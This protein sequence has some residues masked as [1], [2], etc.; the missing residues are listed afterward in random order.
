MRKKIAVALAVVSGVYLF[1]PEPT[2]V[3]PIIG[4]LDEGAALALLAWSMKTLGITP[5]AMLA[6]LRGTPA[7]TP[8]H[9]RTA[10]PERTLNERKRHPL[11]PELDDFDDE[12]AAATRARD[13]TPA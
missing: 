12:L 8:V 11:D 6:R 4:W 10:R 13:V 5:A 9:V 1:V 7:P 3:I 2:D